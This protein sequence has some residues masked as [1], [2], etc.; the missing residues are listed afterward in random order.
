MHRGVYQLSMRATDLYEGAR[1]K[2]QKLLNAAS[3]KEIVFTRGT[4]EAVNLVASTYGRKHVG[5]GDEVLITRPRA[6]LEHRAVA[7]PLRGEGRAAAGRAH[8]RRRRGRPR[9]AG[10]AHR[11]RAR[12][13]SRWPTSRTPS[14]RSSRSRRIVEMAHA[15]AC[16]SS[17]TA[18]SRCPTCRWTCAP[19]TATSTPSRA[20]RCT[21]P[22]GSACS[23]ARA[24]IAVGHASLPGR[25]RHDPVGHLREDGLQRDPLQVRGGNAQ[26][27]RRHRPRDGRRLPDGPRPRGHRRL[28][29]RAARLRHRA[30][31]DGA[32]AAAHR[33]RA[34]R[35]PA[36]SPS[37]STASTPTTS[38]R[39]STT[40]G[41]RSA[42]GITARSR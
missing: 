27:R 19:S 4:T 13:S 16:R 2:V 29:G 38:A 11:R 32:G 5:A 8:Q 41:S 39:S 33:H 37:S 42:R 15:A 22:R 10:A 40:R 35:R 18:P 1:V 7:D 36:S 12:G 20:T 34:P 30:P 31:P 24:E 23:T 6:P 17:W 9:G 14:A 3:H 26:H 28:R 21:G 25:R